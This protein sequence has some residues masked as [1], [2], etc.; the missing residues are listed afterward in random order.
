MKL[1]FFGPPGA[2]KGVL[3][4]LVHEATGL[5]HISVGEMLREHIAKHD[6][7]GKQVEQDM[8]Q[9]KLVDDDLSDE[10]VRQRLARDD[11]QNGYL[12][13]GF[14]RDVY[15]AKFLLSIDRPTGIVYVDIPEDDIVDRLMK[16]AAI[17]HRSDD[18]P[19]T[20]RNRLKI[21]H[22]TTESVLVHFMQTGIPVLKVRG[23]YDL[24]T[25]G[26]L[27]VDK[28]VQWQHGVAKTIQKT[29]D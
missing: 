19:E 14:P 16:R 12:L 20:I 23:D 11:C 9:G 10:M 6:E 27:M 13:D 8:S 28:I 26:Q 25:Q 4:N 17:E 2:G 21:Y 3:T 7:I 24:E 1:I 29:T 15:Q 22:E 18:T 5:P